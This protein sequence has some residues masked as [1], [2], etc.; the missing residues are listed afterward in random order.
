MKVLIGDTSSYKAIVLAKF[1]RENYENIEVYGFDTRKFSRKVY[2]RY[3]KKN[4]IINEGSLKEIEDLIKKLEIDVF[5]PV[6]NSKL[7]LFWGNREMF[8]DTLN[9]LGTFDSYKVLNDKNELYLLAKSLNIPVP[10]KYD[11]IQSAQFPYVVKPTNL[12]SAKGVVY[13][14]QE[15]DVPVF[16]NSSKMIIQ[17]YVEGTGV[18]Y[19]FY[20]KN[21]IITNGY[22]HERL[23]EYPVSGGSSTYRKEFID[24]RIKK[25]ASEIVKKLDYTGFAMF[26]YKYTPD[27]KIFLIEVNPR[28]WG[29]VNQGLT[30]GTNYFESILG[31]V[32]IESTSG[33][34]SI[35]T[36]LSPLIFL[37]MF[38]YL[39]N[40][41]FGPFFNFTTNFRRN[42]SDVSLL[43]D[44]MGY[45]S[46]VL[47]KLL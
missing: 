24:H 41:D 45:F 26:E 29:S 27:D 44:F 42:K 11:D 46:V 38:K 23:A 36:Y 15:S 1:I 17:Q 18:G 5:I 20:C 6:I 28:I 34:E 39:L 9:Y 8:G 19:S 31:P 35:N 3:F 13:V 32:K 40:L 47:R 14:R 10:S 7:E 4:S 22:G 43:G 30:N 37:S 21:G 12:S 33:S 25:Y 16:E 2:S